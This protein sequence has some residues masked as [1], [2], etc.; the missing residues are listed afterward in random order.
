MI[1]DLCMK[2]RA[3]LEM[4]LVDAVANSIDVPLWK[5]FGG[6]SDSLSTAATVK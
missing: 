5:L 4:A 3:G 6:V 2:V 1:F